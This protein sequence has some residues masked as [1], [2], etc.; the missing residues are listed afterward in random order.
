MLLRSRSV[1]LHWSS[2]PSLSF[3]QITFRTAFLICHG[4]V[5]ESD[6]TAASTASA[7][8]TMAASVVCG[9]GPG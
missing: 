1:R 3:P 9:T 6:R 2:C 5:S 7:S 8:I 4:D